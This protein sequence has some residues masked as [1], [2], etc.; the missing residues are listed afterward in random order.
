[1]LGDERVLAEVAKIGSMALYFR[2]Q[3]GRVG[4]AQLS[5]DGWQFVPVSKRDD[6]ARINTLYDALKK[7]IRQGWFELPLA[8]AGGVK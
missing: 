4:L 1:A 8:N 6:I 2:T 5:A 3:D 7:Q